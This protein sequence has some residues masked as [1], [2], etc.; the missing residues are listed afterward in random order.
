[1][2]E[3]DILK[4]AVNP[5]DMWMNHWFLLTAG[6][7]DDC[8]MMTVSWG[9]MGC[10]W[11][12]PM[13][14]IMVRPHRHTYKYIEKSD[15][16]TL[17]GFQ[18]KYREALNILG[19]LSGRN[20]WKLAKTD[21]SL[22]PSVKVAAPSYHEA[23]LILECRKLYFQDI[24]PKGFLDYSIQDNYPINDYHRIYF[25]EIVGAFVQK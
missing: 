21:L 10:I 12:R 11:D 8:N 3:V 16:F 15:S 9:S 18:E 20:G 14:Q 13:V 4:L 19:S 6:T 25:G 1:M 5:V 24:N 22:K 2:I 7:F 17:C 23:S